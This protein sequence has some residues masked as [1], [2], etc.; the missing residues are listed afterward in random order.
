MGAMVEEEVY[1]MIQ[2]ILRKNVEL[3][4]HPSHEYFCGFR[5]N[6]ASYKTATILG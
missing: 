1:F 3:I 2:L 5:I 4:L 6:D